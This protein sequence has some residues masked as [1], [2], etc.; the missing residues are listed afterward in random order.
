MKLTVIA[1]A[2]NAS[3]H[4]PCP[5]GILSC[6]IRWEEPL[7][8]VEVDGKK[9]KQ[10]DIYLSKNAKYEEKTLSLI[11]GGGSII[12]DSTFKKYCSNIEI[13]SKFKE[14]SYADILYRSRWNRCVEILTMD[15]EVIKG[16]KDQA[17]G[18][19]IIEA[20]EVKRVSIQTKIEVSFQHGLKRLST[21]MNIKAIADRTKGKAEEPISV[22]AENGQAYMDK[23][24]W[25]NLARYW[26]A[27]HGQACLDK[28]GRVPQKWFVR[29]WETLVWIWKNLRILL[30]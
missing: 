28:N 8:I 2:K 13:V 9:V 17:T 7:T 20:F 29:I 3:R 23:N 16:Y 24:T 11:D 1:H 5:N 25:E 19:D 30:K 27:K 18:K 4:H 10:Q 15:I 12:A 14:P 26:D 21:Q 22:F 6:F